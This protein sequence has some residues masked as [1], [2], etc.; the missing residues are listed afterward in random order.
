MRFFRSSGIAGIARETLD[1]VFEACRDTHPNEFIGIMKG[2]EASDIGVDR[3]G[4]VVTEVMVIPGTK[5]G[6][7]RAT[8]R[9]DM[10]PLNLGG[11]G[12]VHSHPSGV[13]EPSKEDLITF[14]KKG[15]RHIIVAS[16]YMMDSWQCFDSSGEPVDIEVLDVDLEDVGYVYGD[17]E[18]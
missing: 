13:P 7:T 14:S 17:F 11:V 15:K 12:T 10:I 1:F 6:R 3:D 9:D 5:S 4:Q 2:T 16:P 8:L 18:E